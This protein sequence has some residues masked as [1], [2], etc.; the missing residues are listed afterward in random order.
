M[1]AAIQETRLSIVAAT[2]GSAAIIAR[3][4]SETFDKSWAQDDVKA[5]LSGPGALASIAHWDNL[6]VGYILARSTG[7]EA[8][9]L[10]VGVSPSHRRLGIGG[11]LLQHLEQ[12]LQNTGTGKLFL[13]VDATNTGALKLYS[14]EGFRKIGTRKLYYKAV[15][16]K[17]SDALVLRKYLEAA[18]QSTVADETSNDDRVTDLLRQGT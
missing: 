6:A 5:L 13:E 4:Q 3:L 1:T 7:E 14:R 17:R 2:T 9:L 16:G 8:E 11:A 15:N 12:A 10:S 18:G